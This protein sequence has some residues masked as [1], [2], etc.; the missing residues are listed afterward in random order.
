[1]YQLNDLLECLNISL[2]K[3]KIVAISE[4]I[5]RIKEEIYIQKIRVSSYN[6]E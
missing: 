1:M 6:L 5:L 2:R 3:P 4:D